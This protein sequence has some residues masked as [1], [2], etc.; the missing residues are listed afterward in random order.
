MSRY[1]LGIDFETTGLD[2][3]TDRIIE[4]GAVLW[5]WDRQL[6]ID[7]ISKLCWHTDDGTTPQIPELIT[8]ITG[9]DGPMLKE[10]SVS[11]SVVLQRLMS[12]SRGIY[13][14]AHNAP[15][16][17]GFLF[18]EC[19]KLGIEVQYGAGVIDSRTDIKYDKDL[20]KSRALTHLAASHGFLNPFAHRA[21]FDVLTMLKVASNYDLDEIIARSKSPNVVLTA[22]VS[23]DEKDK[24]KAAGFHW[25][26]EVKSWQMTI[27][28]C[29]L[30]DD[31]GFGFRTSAEHA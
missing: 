19:D 20:H 25:K 5:D 14:M 17:M 22:H 21:V 26:P 12:M 10:H 15:F 29:D 1:I 27:K 18:A 30:A 3:K 13:V 9:I 8:K 28:Q 6:P 24:A 31:M 11:T 23:F 7:M 16:D 2:S 4:V